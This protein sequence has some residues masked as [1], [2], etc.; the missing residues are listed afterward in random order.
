M[1]AGLL[2][3]ARL[4]GIARTLARHDALFPLEMF[5]VAPLLVAALKR[6]PRGKA[7]GRP[8]ER[9]SLALQA[10]GP[11]FIKF[12]QSLAVRS[13]LLGE[14][15]AEDLSAL[16]DRLPAFPSIEA[17]RTVER[18]L[19]APVSSLFAKFEDRPIAAASIAQVHFAETVE[20]EPVAVKV[21]RPGIEAEF[22][23]D[24]DFFYWLARMVLHAKPAL[25]RLRPLEMVRTFEETVLLE[26][27]LR[28]EAAAAD[29]LGENA[30]GDEDFRVPKVDWQHTARRVLTLERI[31]GIPIDEVER[32]EDANFD[33]AEI[34][35]RSSHVFF[36]QVFRD[37]FFHAD[38]HPG[39]MFV[40][41]DG[42]L[43]PVDF[44]IMGRLDKRTRNFLADLLLGF[45]HRDYRRVAE[46]HFAAGYVPPHKS[47]DAF[48]QACRAIAEPI[49]GKPQHE[50]S[51]AH[52]LGQLFHVTET[53]EM[54]AQPQLL[55]LQ[56]T[57]LV[58]EGVGRRLH[59]TSNMWLMA[60]PLIEQWMREN[61]GP[62][63]RL[64]DAADEIRVRIERLP[65]LLDK[66]EQLAGLVSDRGLKLDTTATGRF[67][68][69]G[70][71]GFTAGQ[72]RAVALL[73]IALLALTII[74]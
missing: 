2:H 68:S 27:D 24:I 73:A 46:V 16:Q 5:G 65:S 63:A 41:P 34:M 20:G 66:A 37:G 45:L 36:N 14:E 28:L 50:I 25:A 58:A 17:R 32:L 18:E 42:A 71:G 40:A 23:R 43:V 13:D 70:E 51:I 29:E 48:M 62:E 11:S 72:W 15:M 26:L 55:L 67:G 49:F 52:L 30:A 33:P 1:I 61:R 31:E 8:G 12:G 59:P 54:E 69:A 7:S 38:M 39:N 57:M 47:R 74:F 64:A 19:G 53:F 6:L 21:L 56:K 44:G 4:I 60:E 3:F 9:L 10:L 35:E 22:R